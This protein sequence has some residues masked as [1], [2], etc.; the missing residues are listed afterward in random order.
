MN[1]QDVGKGSY[2]WDSERDGHG[3][4]DWDLFEGSFLGD[5]LRRA[6]YIHI[7]PAGLTTDF[8]L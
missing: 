6:I 8:E 1:W 7:Y 5:D 2:E 3:D 4:G